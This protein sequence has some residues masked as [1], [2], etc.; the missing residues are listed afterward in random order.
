MILLPALRILPV[1]YRSCIYSKR[2][3]NLF[4]YSKRIKFRCLLSAF[5]VHP[6]LPGLL[7]TLPLPYI[8]L[9]LCDLH[10]VYITSG[11]F[12]KVFRPIGDFNLFLERSDKVNTKKRTNK[13]FTLA[14]E[15]ITALNNV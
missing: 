3:L 1:H 11:S 12:S 9:I 13:K 2:K 7:L 10:H 14:F 8:A 4:E 15:L 6:A 5:Y